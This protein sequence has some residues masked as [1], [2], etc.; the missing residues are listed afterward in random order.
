MR[1]RTLDS[2]PSVGDTLNVPC[3]CEINGFGET[4]QGTGLTVTRVARVI[5]RE[6]TAVDARCNAHGWLAT[7]LVYP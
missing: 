7:F 3:G 1:M 5:G 2:V 6:H 4:D